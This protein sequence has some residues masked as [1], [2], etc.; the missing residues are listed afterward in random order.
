M[1]H[2]KSNRVKKVDQEDPSDSEENVV[3]SSE[4]VTNRR[5]STRHRS[6][7]KRYGK[8]YVQMLKS[9]Q[10]RRK[11][12]PVVVS[13]ESEDDASPVDELASRMKTTALFEER[14]DVEGQQVYG[15]KTPKKRYSMNVLVASVQKTPTT[16]GGTPSKSSR[17][18][19]AAAGPMTPKHSAKRNMNL[20]KTPHRDRS[21]LKKDIIKAIRSESDSDF[22]AS[23]SDF[24]PS[25][26]D[27]DDESEGSQEEQDEDEDS[28][29][30][31]TVP[32]VKRAP[33]SSQLASIAIAP[34]L[35]SSK[36]ELKQRKVVDYIPQSD[37]YFGIHSSSKVVTS[38]HTLDRLNTPRLPHDELFRLLKQ[39]HGSKEHE[40]A[41][42][43][44]HID[45]E[46]Y[47]AKWLFLMDEG[48]NILLYGLGSKR[49]LL[50]AFHRKIIANHPALV[51]NGFFPS[52]TLKDILDSIAVD[53]LDLN[54]HSS[55][56]NEVVEL[57]EQ[58]LSY[59]PDTHLFLV[60]HNI[61]GVAIR[62]HKVQTVLARL[63]KL[64]NI[65][66]LGS[67]DHINTPLMWDSSKLSLYNFSWWDVTTMLPYAVETSFENSLLVQNSGAIALSSMKN[68]FQS[69]TTNSRGIFLM[70]AKHQL[71][72]QG[73]QQYQGMLFKD[74]YW[75]CREAFLVSTDLALRA[76]LTEFIDHKLVKVKR[77]ADGSENLTIPIESALL[78]QFLE[79][80]DGD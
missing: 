18:S 42:Q 76:Q 78:T 45:Y 43:S 55:N 62:N 70:I 46:Q 27:E 28:E 52:L 67:I 75:K 60:I 71:A 21:R 11:D 14:V 40:K 37:E 24:V 47:F 72:N 41:I 54:I 17:K 57:I 33:V 9:P 69:L 59:L 29:E 51:I 64:S 56:P 65:H 30:E 32:V 39:F 1:S 63:A 16:A 2:R 8:E 3:P 20:A 36:K 6:P 12:E 34:G 73:N 58:E 23:E 50:Q 66:V 38:D 26:E 22:A 80:N 19:M 77:T 15:F 53:I 4:N 35:K 13:D 5:R 74:L 49:N 44:L 68:V 10:S 48:F 31:V 25:S 61:D 7:N 79:E